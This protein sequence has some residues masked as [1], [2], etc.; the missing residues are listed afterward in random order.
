MNDTLTLAEKLIIAQD[1]LRA[2][3]VILERQLAQ[4]APEQ[5]IRV[6]KA[7]RDAWRKILGQIE[8]ES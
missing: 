2:M 7:E 5:H 3:D 6:A 1:T 8:N 4:D